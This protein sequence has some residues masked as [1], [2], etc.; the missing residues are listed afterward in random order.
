MPMTLQ[1]LAIFAIVLLKQAGATSLP[2]QTEAF[3]SRTVAIERLVPGE[4]PNL[5]GY[6][7]IWSDDVVVAPLHSVGP[8]D[9][10]VAISQ[11]GRFHPVLGVLG[12]VS[13]SDV[14]FLRVKGVR[15]SGP[16]AIA[17][18]GT[19]A[20]LKHVYIYR[21]REA[22]DRPVSQQSQ[23]DTWYYYA[24]GEHLGLKA[25]SIP[26]DS[27]SPVWTSDGKFV[28]LVTRGDD[29]GSSCNTAYLY[30]DLAIAAGR[31]G[32]LDPAFARLSMYASAIAQIENGKASLDTYLE[33]FRAT[34]IASSDSLRVQHR[35]DV[36]ARISA[37]Q[38]YAENCSDCHILFGLASDQYRTLDIEAT[39]M[40][41]D[42]IAD[43]RCSP[44][45]DFLR[46][47]IR[48]Y[49][50]ATLKPEE[51][52]ELAREFA[53]RFPNFWGSY[54]ELLRTGTQISSNTM[55][56]DAL[57]G[58]CTLAPQSGEQWYSLGSKAIRLADPRRLDLARTKLAALGGVWAKRFQA[59]EGSFDDP[60]PAP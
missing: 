22:D 38:Q 1:L 51:K 36:R 29:T 12:H 48:L 4:Q 10:L 8:A 52:A 2:A 42:R 18:Y 17:D 37:L 24:P 15:S 25:P 56:L 14:A 26:G 27:G 9:R 47:R 50:D 59:L 34:G 30:S 5:R 28:G 41:L 6:G 21:N 32:E 7:I 60:A 19:V 11:D 31:R 44:Y 46:L 57:E 23:V 40:T 58:F 49:H 20:A 54:A 13:A 33:V 55:I 45:V 3:G 16:P 53:A 39:R 35:N 43:P